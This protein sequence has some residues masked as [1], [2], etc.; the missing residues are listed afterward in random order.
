VTG[1]DILD[2]GVEPAVDSWTI[3]LWSATADLHFC[4]H[5]HRQEGELDRAG[6]W[7][8]RHIRQYILG[9]PANQARA[10]AM[11]QHFCSLVRLSAKAYEASRAPSAHARRSFQLACARRLT[12]RLHAALASAKAENGAGS[13]Y[14]DEAEA[15]EAALRAAAVDPPPIPDGEG[16]SNWD[17]VAMRHGKA[18]ADNI[19]L[20][21]RD[22]PAPGF[23]KPSRAQP[24]LPF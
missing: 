19:S 4:R 23:R 5:F 10:A 20:V 7:R 24:Q 2:C 13:S 12:A 15:N 3:A 14:A 16:I 1:R 18:A 11:A 21:L 6:R 22:R 8:R 9:R 17:R